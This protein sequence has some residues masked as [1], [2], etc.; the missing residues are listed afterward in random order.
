MKRVRKQ[1]KLTYAPRLTGA[2]LDIAQDLK[3]KE[4]STADI[5]KN[6]TTLRANCATE[7][8]SLPKVVPGK[9]LPPLAHL[10]HFL[11]QLDT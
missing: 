11:A 4:M 8:P 1:P 3:T 7:S 6:V 9:A 5:L 10:A 2:E